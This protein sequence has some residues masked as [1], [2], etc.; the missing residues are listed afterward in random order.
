[1][2]W[3]R[4][5]HDHGQQENDMSIHTSVKPGLRTGEFAELIIGCL[6]HMLPTTAIRRGRQDEIVIEADDGSEW[7]LDINPPR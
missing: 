6:N 2:C 5:R 4:E 1:V 7:R 3:A